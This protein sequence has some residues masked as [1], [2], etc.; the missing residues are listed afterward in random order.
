MDGFDYLALGLFW[1]L[2]SCSDLNYRGA[3]FAGDYPVDCDRDFVVGRDFD[4]G[5]DFVVDRD[6]DSGRGADSDYRVVDFA[7]DYLAGCDR[8]SADGR[9]DDFDFA[10]CFFVCVFYHSSP[11]YANSRVQSR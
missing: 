9:R 6:F 5:R 2:C 7:G 11:E 8:N 10:V 4:S 1:N 3:D